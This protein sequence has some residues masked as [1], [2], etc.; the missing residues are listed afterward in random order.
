M[1][2]SSAQVKKSSSC[3]CDCIIPFSLDHCNMICEKFTSPWGS[4]CS[5]FRFYVGRSEF[6]ICEHEIPRNGIHTH[7]Y[8]SG[9][10]KKKRI[11]NFFWNF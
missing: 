7:Q 2:L 6:H 8:Y 5:Y 1:C 11:S 4:F 3:R 9:N 10:E